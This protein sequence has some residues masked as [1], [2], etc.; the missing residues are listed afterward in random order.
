MRVPERIY[1]NNQ[2]TPFLSLPLTGLDAITQQFP[3]A[4]IITAD[5]G[6][7]AL[8][9]EGET[10][11]WRVGPPCYYARENIVPAERTEG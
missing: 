10:C 5:D 8:I 7:R 4:G 2:N 11:L 9:A 3:V 1:R 6:R